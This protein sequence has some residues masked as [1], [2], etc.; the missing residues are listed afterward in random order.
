VSK[1]SPKK[2]RNSRVARARLSI[3]EDKMIR[4]LAKANSLDVS[5]WIRLQIHIEYKRLSGDLPKGDEVPDVGPWRS[6]PWKATVEKIDSEDPPATQASPVS[7]VSPTPATSP[8]PL[9]RN[10]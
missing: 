6:R 9:P 2:T 3:G 7:P 1:L 10:P 4:A 8:A 5:E